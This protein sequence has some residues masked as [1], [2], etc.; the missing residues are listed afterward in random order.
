M[1]SLFLAPALALLF[2]CSATQQAKIVAFEA[3]AAPVIASA[4]ANLHAVEANP[5]LQ[6]GIDMG[7]AASAATGGAAGL[8]DS[9]VK[10][11]GDAYCLNGPPAGD[12]TTAA[13]QAAWLLGKII[14]PLSAP[15][16]APAK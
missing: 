16:V 13:Q 4:C 8:A 12:T 7:V 15:V 11:M 10:G 3:K 6:G 1:K 2:G 5:L 9:V 14:P